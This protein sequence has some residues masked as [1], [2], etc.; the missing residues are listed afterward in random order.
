MMT[1]VHTIHEINVYHPVV[2]IILGG[3]PRAL[4]PSKS[5]HE[6]TPIGLARIYNLVS[7]VAKRYLICTMKTLLLYSISSVHPE[8]ALSKSV[9]YLLDC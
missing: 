6:R 1:D 4:G 7:I 2:T 5:V 8:I 9:Q 3:R